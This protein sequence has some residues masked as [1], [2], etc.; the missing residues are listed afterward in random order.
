MEHRLWCPPCGVGLVLVR[1][2]VSVG[3]GA[4]L[5][6]VCVRV[7][8]AGSRVVGVGGG[9]PSRGGVGVGT[10]LGPEGR[11]PWVVWRCLGRGPLG[12]RHLVWWPYLVG[13]SV[14]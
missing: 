10:L 9:R 3:G 13:S 5:C 6:A 14:A 11:G 4:G 8:A 1:L 12:G 2:L 7:G